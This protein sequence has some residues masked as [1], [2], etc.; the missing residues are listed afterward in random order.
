MF[1][2]LKKNW[3]KKNLKKKIIIIELRFDCNSKLFK[4][5]QMLSLLFKKKF[6]IN[7]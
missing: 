6:E 3:K 5:Y 2:C 1:S 7:K 4:K